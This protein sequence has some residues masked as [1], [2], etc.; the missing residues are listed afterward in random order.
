MRS[1]SLMI[2]FRG[3][4]GV[5]EAAWTYHDDEYGGKGAESD[6]LI[7]VGVVVR[8]ATVSC[9]LIMVLMYKKDG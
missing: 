1:V 2:Q 5:R 6:R 7:R 8:S 9:L 3:I 4:S